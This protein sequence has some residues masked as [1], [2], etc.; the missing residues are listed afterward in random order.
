MIGGSKMN[1]IDVMKKVIEL[2]T[3][4]LYTREQSLKVMMQI[5]II[6]KAFGVK[7]S[8]TD[9]E[10]RDYERE[11]I[12]NEK[13]ISN[14]FNKYVDFWEIAKERQDDKQHEYK[15]QVYYFIAGVRFFNSELANSF[16]KEMLNK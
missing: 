9:E 1:N 5:A 6:R 16:E 12:L 8:E 15:R 11:I 13:E 10:V 2:D 14:E 7:N 3:Q 4:K